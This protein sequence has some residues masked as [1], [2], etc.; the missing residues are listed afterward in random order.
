[1]Y[2]YSEL[3]IFDKDISRP[4][5]GGERQGFLR[6]KALVRAITISRSKSIVNLPPRADYIHHLDFSGEEQLLYDDAKKQTVVLLQAAISSSQ[7]GRTFNALQ[8]LNT[9]R[10]I[11]SH[12]LLAQSNQ[13]TET[14]FQ[15]QSS[16]APCTQSYLQDP[17][18][19]DFFG[20]RSFCCYCGMDLLEDFLEGSPSAGLYTRSA[21]PK[22][23][24]IMC[25]RCQIQFEIPEIR[26]SRLD[27]LL[28]LPMSPLSHSPSPSIGDEAAPF[29]LELMP[30]KVKALV[31]DLLH[32]SLSE[33]RC[34]PNSRCLL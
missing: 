26:S 31:T 27:E 17:F 20:G 2:P 21:A 14:S 13:G 6:L 15:A 11:C 33:K 25:E 12:G 30:T 7:G 5:R 29:P 34:V 3:E 10:L 16:V 28:G 24:P 23:G 19:E 32:H 4:W 22:S 1:V 8:R 9:L 18:Y